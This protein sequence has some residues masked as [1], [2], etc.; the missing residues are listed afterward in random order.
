[1]L[2]FYR[3]GYFPDQFICLTESAYLFLCLLLLLLLLSTGTICCVTKD[4]FNR[5]YQRILFISS[6]LKCRGLAIKFQTAKQVHINCTV[7]I[8]FNLSACFFLVCWRWVELTRRTRIRKTIG[9]DRQ[10]ANERER[11]RV[12]NT[13]PSSKNRTTN[14]VACILSFHIRQPS[15]CWHVHCVSV[16]ACIYGHFVFHMV[17]HLKICVCALFQSQMRFKSKMQWHYAQIRI[18]WHARTFMYIGAHKL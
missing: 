11:K 15:L 8:L 9:N 17:D 13:Q 6:I 7:R 10:R 3:L 18:H 2:L 1:M 4:G 12:N 14:L 16:C 5:K